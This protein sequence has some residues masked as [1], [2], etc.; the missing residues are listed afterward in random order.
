MQRPTSIITRLDSSKFAGKFRQLATILLIIAVLLLSVPPAVARVAAASTSTQLSMWDS[1]LPGLW[2]MWESTKRLF[3]S[4]Q[5]AQLPTE[6]QPRPQLFPPMPP[7][8]RVER[9]ARVR[10]IELNVPRLVTLRSGQE[11]FFSAIAVGDDGQAVQGLPVRWESSDENVIFIR[12]DGRARLDEPDAAGALTQSTTYLYDTLNNLIKVTQGTEQQR[13][14]KYDSLSRLTFER[15]IEQDAP[16]QQADALTGNNYWSHKIIYNADNLITDSWDARGVQTHV[17]YDGLNRVSQITYAGEPASTTTPA[18]T[19][20]Y[21][22]QRAG[23]FNRGRLTTVT[24][25]AGGGTLTPVPQT[26]QALDYDRMGRVQSKRQ[27]IGTNTYTIGYSFNLLGELQSET[28]PSGRV[29]STSYDAAARPA[30]VSDAGQTYASSFA[31]AGHGAL[32]G[33]TWGNG[34]VHTMG[35]NERL[36]LK[37]IKLTVGGVEKQ[38]YDYRYGEVNVNYP[39]LNISPALGLDTSKNTGQVALIEG[40]IDGVRQWQ[41]RLAYD[42]LGRLSTARELTDNQTQAGL[43]AWRVDYT[44]DRWGNRYQGSGQG[45]VP[46]AD[47]DIDKTRNR[48]VTVGSTQMIYDAAGNL[49]IDQKFRGMQFTYDANSRMRRTDATNGFTTSAYDAAGLKVQSFDSLTNIMRHTVYDAYG[50]A[51]SDYENGAWKKD[52][53]YRGESDVLLAT[54]EAGSGVRY[55]LFD[56]QGSTRV[57]ANQSGQITERHDYRPF[58]EELGAG[59]GLR[60]MPQGYSVSNP[61]RQQYALTERESTGLN[62]TWFRKSDSSA[63]RWTSPDPYNGSMSVSDPQS[64]NRYSYVENDPVNLVDPSG[65][66]WALQGCETNCVTIYGETS[67]TT[68]CHYKWAED[69]G[70]GMGNGGGGYTGHHGTEPSA[71]AHG[72]SGQS[73]CGRLVDILVKLASSQ[74]PLIGTNAF[75][76]NLG[77]SMAFDATGAKKLGRDRYNRSKGSLDINGFRPELTAGGKVAMSINTSSAMRELS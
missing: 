13:Y 24:T 62:H 1:A 61:I 69:A 68:T 46:V 27:T 59:I 7:Q 58:G 40:S 38:R 20:T 31:Y 11:T 77:R 9:E 21:D 25:A 33:E 47:T 66:W 36:Q 56:H 29:V 41:Q 63:G 12:P 52:Y 71:R 43:E 60:S 23:Y 75:E 3:G 28:Y 16:Y 8:T 51:L 26:V 32:T 17:T 44:Y 39:T 49:T 53:I 35:Y 22:E 37:L 74:P 10:G 15:Q 5:V 67:C 57:V 34:A 76:L 54:V 50:R 4:A 6:Q 30:T 64:F 18:V 2:Q 65:L 14:F 42:K 72:S 45:N 73:A 48:F 55:V 70:S 19:Y